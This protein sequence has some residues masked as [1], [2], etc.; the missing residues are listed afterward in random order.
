MT[1]KLI[2]LTIIILLASAI[3]SAERIGS[4]SYYGIGDG[5]AG[6]RTSDGSRMNPNAFTCASWHYPL[7]TKLEVIYRHKFYA[8]SSRHGKKIKVI[9]DKKVI[10]KVND[11]GGLHLLDLSAGAFKKL[12]PLSRGVI[13]VRVRRVK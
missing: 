7:G 11:R 9:I 5:F 8:W 2:T 12:A 3:C 13:K 1:K 6:K 10:V 4:A